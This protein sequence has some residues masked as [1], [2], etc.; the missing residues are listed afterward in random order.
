MAERNFMQMIREKWGQGKFLCLGL[1]SDYEKLPMD[2]KK[3]RD[4]QDAIIWFNCDIINATGD[5]F[6][7]CKLNI[8]FYEGLGTAGLKALHNT[9]LYIK[10]A[11]E[12][13]PI[14]LDAKRGD[15]ENTNLG[16]IRY[17]FDILGVDAITV[18]PYMG[19]LSLAPFLE[20]EDK[21]IFILCRTSNK[22]SDELQNLTVY[23]DQGVVPGVGVRKLPLYQYV[24]ERV[25]KDWNKHGNCGLVV[26]ATYPEEAKEIRKI[27]PQLPF[28]IPGI[29]AQGGDVKKTV[30]AAKDKKGRGMI[31]N[32]S[33]G[34]IF[35][36]SGSDYAEAARREA[37]KLHKEINHYLQ[38]GK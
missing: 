16:Y 34:I 17:A 4:A 5:L 14:I 9:V 25:A 6:C 20:K 11:L 29:G 35:A 31:I 26:G 27:A 28:L 36:S 15:I 13:V 2:A 30:L 24:A 32:S 19:Q 21:G 37:E 8:A 33:R 7:A 3:G 10:E 12:D 18:P 38:G 1:D 22:G 23:L